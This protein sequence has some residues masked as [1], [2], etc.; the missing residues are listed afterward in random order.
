MEET[1]CEEM[2]ADK[3]QVDFELEAQAKLI[4]ELSTLIPRLDSKIKSIMLPAYPNCVDGSDKAESVLVPLAS[5]LKI[6]NTKL[7]LMNNAIIEI[8]DRIQL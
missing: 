3:T 6:N 8:L 2:K 7:R 4:G 1:M 5:E